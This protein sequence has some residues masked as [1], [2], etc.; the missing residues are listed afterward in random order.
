[1]TIN[2]VALT[3][4]VAAAWFLIKRTEAFSI[5]KAIWAYSLLLASFPLYYWAFA[6]YAG[7]YSALSNEILI[8]SLFIIM[9]WLA[10]VQSKPLALFI[11]ALGFI[12]HAVYDITHGSF[13]TSAVAPIWW[14]EFCGSA[15]GVIGLYLLIESSRMRPK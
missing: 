13:G 3:I 7:N 1:M 2:I 5:Q 12:A 8:G 14:P 4:G 9:A 11:L 10:Y 6:I 15:D